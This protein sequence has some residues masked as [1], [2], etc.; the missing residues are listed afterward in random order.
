M[1]HLFPLAA[2]LV[3]LPSMAPAFQMPKDEEAARFV[4][5]NIVSTFYHELGHALIDVMQLPVL[6]REED[7]AD[8]LSGL[9]I[10]QIWQEDTAFAMITDSALAYVLY[11]AENP[12]SP[13][14]Q[15]FWDEHGLDLQ[16]SY[17]LVCIFYG[18][19]PE[20]R[21]EITK[22]FEL[23]E[24]RAERCPDEY[25]QAQTSWGAMLEQISES[26]NTKGLVLDDALGM[27]PIAEILA[28]EIKSLNETYRLPEDV[29]VT[30]A[31]CGEPNA[32]YAPDDRSIT[33]C[34]E[35]AEDLA[36]LWAES[37]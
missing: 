7:A 22:I 28:E 14:E 5:S 23:P 10:D 32:Y 31:P 17:N 27:D 30:V 37:E 35:L 2:L 29:F 24:S 3:L 33:I 34:T 1:R 19:N 20:G 9:L 8:T 6:G 4:T 11:D 36:R 16:R 12:T 26:E 18:A 15:P 25:V 13:D 21:A